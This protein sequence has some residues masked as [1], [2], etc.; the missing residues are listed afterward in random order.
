MEEDGTLYDLK[1][2]G[3]RTKD[4]IISSPAP[5]HETV[6]LNGRDGMIDTGTSLGP[7]D[8]TLRLKMTAKDSLD[9]GLLR[10]EIFRTLRGDRPFYLIEKRNPHK[11]W[12]VKVKDAFSIPQNYVYGDFEIN[13]IS[14]SSYSESMGT[15]LAPLTLDVE[16]WQVAQGLLAEDV[17]YVHNTTS[18]QIYNAGDAVID[19]REQYLEITFQGESDYLTINNHSTGDSWEYYGY[20]DESDII[21]LSGVRAMKGNTSIFSD[22][23]RNL[24]RLAPGWNS[25]S[26]FGAFWD[27]EIKFDFRYLYL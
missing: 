26:T 21:T 1:K 20:T 14:F 13:L 24:I 19:P 9:F 2:A 23:N 17:K 18:F 5:R 12:R 22:T 11:R 25:F 10:D 27:L 3:I 7:R 6:E 8:I 16:T 15:S 4:I